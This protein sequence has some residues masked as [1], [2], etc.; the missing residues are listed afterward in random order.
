MTNLGRNDPC[1][2]GSGKKYKK[3]HLEADQRHLAQMRP[4]KADSESPSAF[5]DVK[6][7]PNLL[8]QFSESTPVKERENFTELLAE[9]ERL[10]E[11][12]AGQGEIE[13]AG[14]E[15][16]TH[17][18]AFDELARDEERYSALAQAVFAEECFVPLRFTAADVQRAFDNVGHPALMS[19]DERTVATLRAAILHLADKKRR[20][21]LSLGLMTRLPE[22]VRAGR[23]MEGWLVQCAAVA[24]AEDPDESNPFLFHMFSFGYDAWAA[25][26]HAKDQAL[27]RTMG[28]DLDRLREMNLNELDSWIQAHASDPANAGV[29]E[30]FFEGNPHL[31][32]ESAANLQAL[33]RDSVKLLEGEDTRFLLIPREEVQ[34]WLARWNDRFSQSEFLSAPDAAAS[35]EGVRRMFEE[36]ALPMM[37]EMTEAIFSPDRIQQLVAELK[38]YRNDRFA[39]GD[40]TAAARAMGAI[41]YLAEEDSPGENIFLLTLCWRSLDSAIKACTAGDDQP[42]E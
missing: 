31:R 2:C 24:T 34:P 33:E 3:C 30:A 25:E 6:N 14:A 29:L 17:R 39:A 35:E 21:L 27:L 41:N 40:K 1:H 32:E 8:R 28:V 37:R 38:K 12:M 13:A 36:L 7:L 16:E 20:S 19:P 23:Y 5:A 18:A 22:F 26:K 11:Y 42:A 10:L 15:L 4:S 9:S